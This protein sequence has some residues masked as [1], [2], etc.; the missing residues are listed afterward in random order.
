MVNAMK[1]I[2]LIVLA[3]LI[4]VCAVTHERWSEAE[5]LCASFGGASAASVHRR[6]HECRNGVQV[7]V[8]Q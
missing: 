7:R 8:A 4:R 6:I 1:E 2:S 3:I 5:R